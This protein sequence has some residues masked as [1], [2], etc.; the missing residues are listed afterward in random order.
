MTKAGIRGVNLQD[1]ETTIAYD[2][3]TDV[4]D[5]IQLLGRQ[6]RIGSAFNKN[7]VIFL[8]MKETIDEYKLNYVKAHSNVVTQVLEGS[9]PLPKDTSTVSK[10]DL[11][12]M[13]KQ[14]LWK[15]RKSKNGK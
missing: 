8:G 3:P 14:F 1:C 11:T 5:L 12:A 6:S 7:Y 15:T 9:S 2:T 10:E 13:R 4:K